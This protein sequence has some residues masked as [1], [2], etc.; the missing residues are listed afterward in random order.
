MYI[1]VKFTSL[2]H[3]EF[4]LRQKVTQSPSG[5]FFHKVK[6]IFDKLKYLL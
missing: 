2:P 6:L 3:R 4:K 1:F 5:C